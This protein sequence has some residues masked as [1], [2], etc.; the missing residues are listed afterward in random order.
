[1]SPKVTLPSERP[2]SFHSEYKRERG[3]P[4]GRHSYLVV[5]NEE[6]LVLMNRSHPLQYL[7]LRFN[8][9]SAPHRRLQALADC[10]REMADQTQD[11]SKVNLLGLLSLGGYLAVLAVGAL[12][13]FIVA[14]WIA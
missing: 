6:A 2:I 11:H 14:L 7:A 4:F 10:L 9:A 13:G 8:A 3:E 5:I 12:L 1:M